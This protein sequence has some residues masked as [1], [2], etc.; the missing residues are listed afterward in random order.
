M[1]VK[2]IRMAVAVTHSCSRGLLS[3]LKALGLPSRVL[4]ATLPPVRG[5]MLLYSSVQTG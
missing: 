2:E 5:E 3:K 4:K 1:R